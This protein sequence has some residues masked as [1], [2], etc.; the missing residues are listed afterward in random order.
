MTTPP[1]EWKLGDLL[2]DANQVAY[3]PAGGFNPT[4]CRLSVDSRDVEP[5]T[6]FIALA[7]TRVDSHRFID[8]VLAR[9]AS[10]VIA[11]AGRTPRAGGVV[12]TVPDTHEAVA[13]LAAS[14]H[15][16][17]AAQ[18][19]GRLHLVGVTGTNGKTTVCALV[20]AVLEAAGHRVASFG[21]IVNDTGTAARASDMTTMAP[22]DLC[23]ELGAAVAAGATHA[24]LEVSSHALDQRRC[25]GLVFDAGVFTN[26]TRDHLDY[27]GSME[28]Y[29]VAK[30]RLFTAL[31]QAA[32]AIACAD[33]AWAEKIVEG[34]AARVVR[35][36]LDAAA[37]DVHAGRILIDNDALH[38]SFT[39][40]GVDGA[41]RE[42]PLTTQLIG[43]HNV[44]N[45][46][47]AVAV[48]DT[49]GVRH[50]DIR[51]GIEAVACVPGRLERVASAAPFRVL[52]DY[53]HTPDALE[54]VLSILRET[55]ARRI[56]C[57]F[58]C[59]GDRDRGKR[60]VMAQMV[61]RSA[62]AA[63]VTSDNPR[64]EQPDAIIAET[65][66]GFAASDRCVHE[67]E[68]DR[69]RA[70]RRAVAMAEAGDIVLIAGKGHEKFQV[71]GAQRLPFDDVAEARAALAERFGPDAPERQ[72]A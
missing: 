65:V 50:D 38:V 53:A 54:N 15:G 29:A 35:Y 66:S 2:A 69:A 25:A 71:V 24:V 67:V 61:G 43:R 46:A 34:I 1:K 49:L 9:G 68:P 41:V 39:L 26:L 45:I 14:Y 10:V 3:T 55:A 22:L 23:R 56:I 5:G 36:G 20:R 62:D 60:P 33:D 70:I 40:R 12:V 7:G 19:A 30:R 27:H 64:S 8:D 63:V 16:V 13:R 21:T 42:L 37:R 18:R 51:R 48:G 47:A 58:G 59:G 4:I 57:V 31:P 6:C 52:V 28:A 17:A 11:E 32:A 72:V 44:R